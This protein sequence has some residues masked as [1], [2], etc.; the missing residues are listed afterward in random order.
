M[1]RGLIE[2]EAD[3][4]RRREIFRNDQLERIANALWV[5]AANG[6]QQIGISEYAIELEQAYTQDY[7]AAFGGSGDYND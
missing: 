1:A 7:L 3:Q 4:A 5:I 2:I 6:H